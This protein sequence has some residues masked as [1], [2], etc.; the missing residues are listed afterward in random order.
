M[1]RES[2]LQA[3]VT[4][5]SASDRLENVDHGIF[6]ILV[7]GRRRLVRTFVRDE[8]LTTD[9]VSILKTPVFEVLSL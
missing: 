8:L 6:V 9:V 4:F 3:V 2:L 5:A 7:F 1:N